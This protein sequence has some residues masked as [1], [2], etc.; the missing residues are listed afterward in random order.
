[1]RTPVAMKT[2]PPMASGK[3]AAVAAPKIE[4]LGKK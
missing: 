4:E 2:P 3:C 1:M